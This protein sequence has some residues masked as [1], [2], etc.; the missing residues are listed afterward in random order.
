MGEENSNE[1]VWDDEPVY[2]DDD[3]IYES[4]SE[5]ENESNDSEDEAI[6]DS[7]GSASAS[8]DCIELSSDEEQN[9]AFEHVF[10]EVC[11][12]HSDRNLFSCQ[13]PNLSFHCTEQF[14]SKGVETFQRNFEEHLLEETTLKDGAKKTVRRK[15]IS[16]ESGTKQMVTHTPIRS[17]NRIS[18]ALPNIRNLQAIT[19]INDDNDDDGS[20][21]LVPFTGANSHCTDVMNMDD[22]VQNQSFQKNGYTYTQTVTKT[23][24]TTTTMVMQ[25]GPIANSTF[26]TPLKGMNSQNC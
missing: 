13:S 12:F 5:S 21:A 8:G 7:E 18:N 15:T 4:D 23:I 3:V 17:S 20:R 24:V 25:P 22:V 14:C 16:N 2:S 19:G 11:S 26:D 9:K 10:K 1:V 6:E